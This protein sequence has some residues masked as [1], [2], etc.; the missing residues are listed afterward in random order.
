M[1]RSRSAAAVAT[2]AALMSVLSTCG[3]GA[4]SD[5]TSTLNIG[6]ICPASGALAEYGAQFDTGFD[7]AVKEVNAAGGIDIDGK[8][9]KVAI[10]YCDSEADPV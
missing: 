2:G 7:L 3:S 1:F 8:K 10:K 6:A 4:G 9:V 5:S